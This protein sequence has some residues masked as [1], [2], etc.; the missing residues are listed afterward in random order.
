MPMPFSWPQAWNMGRA[1]LR[2]G[3][4]SARPRENGHS[5]RP[6]SPPAVVS[7]WNSW[8]IRQPKYP[9]PRRMPSGPA[10]RINRQVPSALCSGQPVWPIVMCREALGKARRGGV[11][12]AP[13]GA[14]RDQAIRPTEP[15]ARSL[16]PLT[17]D[18]A[19]PCNEAAMCHDAAAAGKWGVWSRAL[20]IGQ[21]SG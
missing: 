16:A 12:S 15:F 11:T 17:F 19:T 13:P 3:V 18:H 2:P 4:L 1:T 5:Q 9:R 10:V 21:M 20:L 8:H 6:G 14:E 7:G